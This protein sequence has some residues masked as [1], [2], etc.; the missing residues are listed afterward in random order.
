MTHIKAIGPE[1]HTLSRRIQ[2][3]LYFLV[4]LWNIKIT[5]HGINIHTGSLGMIPWM[6][7]LQILRSTNAFQVPFPSL[8][9][10]L[11]S[12]RVNNTHLSVWQ[13]ISRSIALS[14]PKSLPWLA[15]L[16]WECC[17]DICS[18][19]SWELRYNQFHLVTGSCFMALTDLLA[20][21]QGQGRHVVLLA[22][23]GQQHYR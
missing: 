19:Q 1:V 4:C 23:P 15:A 14:G 20:L 12:C 3:L 10:L 13:L 2:G 22:A 5:L 8:S 11:G 17:C 7:R 6:H 18:H 9:V 16:H 21:A